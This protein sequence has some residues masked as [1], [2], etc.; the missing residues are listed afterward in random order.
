MQESSIPP[1]DRASAVQ[2]LH[3][4]RHDVVRL[5]WDEVMLH[6][7]QGL[8]PEATDGQ[9]TL[10]VARCDLLHGAQVVR[11]QQTANARR[12]QYEWIDHGVMVA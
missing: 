11:L 4:G 12:E 7:T 5:S 1:A 10:R 8:E 6:L 9:Q 3:G 2:R